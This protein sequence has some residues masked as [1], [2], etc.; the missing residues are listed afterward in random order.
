M[1]VYLSND[2]DCKYARQDWR[3]SS[4]QNDYYDTDCFVIGVSRQFQILKET[5]LK[6]KESVSVWVCVAAIEKHVVRQ[7]EQ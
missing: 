3:D 6:F 2:C 4:W 7:T 5:G 1:T